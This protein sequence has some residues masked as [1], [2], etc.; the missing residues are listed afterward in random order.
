M[1]LELQKLVHHEQLFEL[2]LVCSWGSINVYEWRH[3]L[4]ASSL[5]AASN[6]PAEVPDNTFEGPGNIFKPGGTLPSLMLYRLA[7]PKP[8]AFWR[9]LP[10][11]SWELKIDECNPRQCLCSTLSARLCNVVILVWKPKGN[12]IG[13]FVFSGLMVCGRSFQYKM[14]PKQPVLF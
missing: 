14:C 5:E 8:V 7:H 3:L 10:H 6:R 2:C 4:Q 12:E 1:V 9:L 11:L 13:C